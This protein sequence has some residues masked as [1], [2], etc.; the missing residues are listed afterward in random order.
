MFSIC[1]LQKTLHRCRCYRCFNNN[2]YSQIYYECYDNCKNYVTK[3]TNTK[4]SKECYFPSLIS[5]S[6]HWKKLV[7]KENNHAYQFCYHHSILSG[8]KFPE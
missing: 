6:N 4:T 1:V 8:E 2:E 7:K 5:N 3:L